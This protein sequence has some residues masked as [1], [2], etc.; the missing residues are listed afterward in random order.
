SGIL[1]SADLLSRRQDPEGAQTLAETDR[2][3][4]YVARMNRLIGDLL[5]VGSIDAGKLAVAPISGDSTLPIAEALEILAPIA[6]AKRVSLEM[7]VTERP[8]PGRF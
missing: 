7:E 2:I 5:D 8:L 1:M 3:K 4:R 6:S